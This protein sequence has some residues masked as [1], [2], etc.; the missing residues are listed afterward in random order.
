[1]SA[2]KPESA[3]GKSTAAR[4]PRSARDPDS[5]EQA[6]R[7]GLRLL[8]IRARGRAELIR[9]LEEKGFNPLAAR[10]AAA[11]LARDGWL[12]DLAAARSAV[13][14]SSGRYGRARIG[15]EL[16]A[17]GF[18]GETIEAALSEF[19]AA[20]EERTLSR[21]FARVQRAN[22]GLPLEKRRRR[23]WDALIRRGFEASAISAKM[24]GWSGGIEDRDEF[25]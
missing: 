6:R 25:G 21:L 3:T 2:G 19:E 11:G 4:R 23:I 12:D 18:S 20:E 8:T 16:R 13:R 5:A 7:K 17:R 1:V 22:A 10:E 9:S 24:K 14:A 15:R